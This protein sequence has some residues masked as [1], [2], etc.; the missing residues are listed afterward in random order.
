MD[1]PAHARAGFG[2]LWRSLHLWWYSFKTAF[3]LG[4]VAYSWYFLTAIWW[5]LLGL[6][7]VLSLRQ[8]IPLLGAL[9]I[10][11]WLRWLEVH[12]IGLG[13][14]ALGW[15]PIAFMGLAQSLVV[16]GSL[17]R[18]AISALDHLPERSPS[19]QRQAG[20]RRGALLHLTMQTGLS[21][22]LFGLVLVILGGALLALI[23]SITAG[24]T[25]ASSQGAINAD[26]VGSSVLQVGLISA[27]AIGVL[28]IAWPLLWVVSRWWVAEVIV[29]VDPEALAS[30]SPFESWELSQGSVSK[31]LAVVV[32]M[33]VMTL[34]LQV[35]LIGLPLWLSQAWEGGGLTDS[36]RL[37][38]VVL[39]WIL[40]GGLTLPLW[41]NLKAAVYLD[42]CTRR[43]LEDPSEV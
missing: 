30:T 3:P 15:T 32:A 20:L 39:A 29:V 17:T 35:G 18:L 13:F 36:M 8:G 4:A 6:F 38:A 28:V 11:G 9:P 14:V 41:Q 1:R 5:G 12:R 43:S 16:A 26:A 40:G 22:L 2:L 10:P 21:L 27:G 31:I 23:L 24:W 34:S 25:V 7:L 37:V 33:S 19:A 42:L